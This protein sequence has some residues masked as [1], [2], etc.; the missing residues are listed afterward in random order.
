MQR[1][2]SKSYDG[3]DAE[4]YKSYSASDLNPFA[5][6]C[7][8]SAPGKV[9]FTAEMESKAFVA[10]KTSIPDETGNCT[11]KLSDGAED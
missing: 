10:W 5:R 1:S 8:G 7:G 2:D 4:H 11:I 6:P 9:H 3:D